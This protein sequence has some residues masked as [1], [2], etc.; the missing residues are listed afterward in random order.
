[1]VI[2]IKKEEE[3]PEIVVHLKTQLIGCFWLEFVITGCS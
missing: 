2:A 1:V 3:M